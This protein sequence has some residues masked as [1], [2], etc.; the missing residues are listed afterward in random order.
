MSEQRASSQTTQH[1]EAPGK[2]LGFIPY[3]LA[4]VSLSGEGLSSSWTSASAA[5]NSAAAACG[6]AGPE[7]VAQSWCTAISTPT[8]LGT[9]WCRYIWNHSAALAAAERPQISGTMCSNNAV[10][11]TINS[12]HEELPA[13]SAGMA[14]AHFS[15][16]AHC[17]ILLKNCLPS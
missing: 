13:P 16:P 17:N 12:A 6:P 3:L 2:V 15:F 7:E 10:H 1:F 11:V 4:H 8:N 14:R 5:M 9:A